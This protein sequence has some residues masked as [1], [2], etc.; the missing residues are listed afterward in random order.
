MLAF[1]SHSPLAKGPALDVRVGVEEFAHTP[2]VARILLQTL[3]VQKL[4]K[5]TTSSSSRSN[6]EFLNTTDKCWGAKVSKGKPVTFV[7]SA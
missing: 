6:V 4:T 2:G 7:T 1:T 5:V 3:G